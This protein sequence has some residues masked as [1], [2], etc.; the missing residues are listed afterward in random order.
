[1]QR[2]APFAR[3]RALMVAMALAIQSNSGWSRADA[4]ASV[5]GYR[6]RGKGRGSYQASS[7]TDAQVKRAARKARNVKRYKA[8]CRG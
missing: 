6:S 5:G 8:A 2:S 4:L 1:M 7:N 3:F